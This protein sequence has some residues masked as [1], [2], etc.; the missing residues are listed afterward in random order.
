MPFTDESKFNIFK[1]DSHGKIWQWKN[2]ITTVEH[3]G[4]SYW[5][6]AQW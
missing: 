5:L 6:W 1:S 2:L 3:G 4:G